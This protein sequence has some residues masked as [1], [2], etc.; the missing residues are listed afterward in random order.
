MA[1]NKAET[2]KPI[3]HTFNGTKGHAKK[4]EDDEDDDDD[5][6]G[7]NETFIEQYQLMKPEFDKFPDNY[8]VE[9]NK[10]VCRSV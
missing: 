7:M 4:D 6:S 8:K 5:G 1:S 2:K 10:P 9:S 3:D